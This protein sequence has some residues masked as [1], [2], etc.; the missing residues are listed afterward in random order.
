M[1]VA[2]KINNNNNNKILRFIENKS[3]NLSIPQNI[4][5]SV[6]KPLTS[7]VNDNNYEEYNK[8]DKDLRSNENKDIIEFLDR[9]DKWID[10]RIENQI[11]KIMDSLKVPNNIYSRDDVLDFF[12]I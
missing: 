12:I 1:D 7:I 6:I 5:E 4:K 11:V 3:K 8:W 2:E 10:K 9:I